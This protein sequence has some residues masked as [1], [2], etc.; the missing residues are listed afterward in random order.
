M[1]IDADIFKRFLTVMEKEWA[2]SVSSWVEYAMECYSRDSC[3]GCPYAEK[4]GQQKLGIGKMSLKDKTNSQ[5][6]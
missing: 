1:A 3:D 4:K 2:D 5:K 6:S